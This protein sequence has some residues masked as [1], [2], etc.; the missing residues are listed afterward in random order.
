[1]SSLVRHGTP[2]SQIATVAAPLVTSTWS[3]PP[4][5]APGLHAC[6]AQPNKPATTTARKP[7][8]RRPLHTTRNMIPSSCGF[9]ATRE[10]QSPGIPGREKPVHAGDLASWYVGGPPWK[11]TA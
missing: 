1:S 11:H 2:G 8:E 6:A 10:S 7:E 3:F 9:S 4:V 5:G